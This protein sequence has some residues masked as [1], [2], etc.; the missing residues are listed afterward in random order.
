M[1]QVD[2][3]ECGKAFEAVDT[4]AGGLTNCPGCGKATPVPGLRDPLFRLL[5]AS[6]VIGWA[7][8]TAWGWTAGGLQGGLIMGIGTAL[9][10]GLLYLTL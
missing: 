5:Q 1:V 2:C 7:L 10:V 3:E 9:M 4:L 8:V 6:I